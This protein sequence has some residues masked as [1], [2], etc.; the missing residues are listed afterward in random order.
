MW[1]TP[2]SGSRNLV[3]VSWPKGQEAE[4]GGINCLTTSGE[5]MTASNQLVLHN[6]I[7]LMSDGRVYI[8]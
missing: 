6:R 3:Q 8:S 2:W 7:A 1:L 5:A 4:S